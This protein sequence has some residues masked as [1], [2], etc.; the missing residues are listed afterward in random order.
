IIKPLIRV[1]FLFAVIIV[2]QKCR[3]VFVIMVLYRTYSIFFNYKKTRTKR[4]I[5]TAT[6]F[7]ARLLRGVE[8]RG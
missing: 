4:V 6:M 5:S 2:S 1:A 7:F 8:V 3:V